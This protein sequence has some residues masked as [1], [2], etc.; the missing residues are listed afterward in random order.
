MPTIKGCPF[1][2][3]S[4]NDWDVLLW[5]ER[6]DSPCQPFSPAAISLPDAVKL[7]HRQGLSSLFRP[8]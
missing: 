4:M 1:E 7:Y 2:I 3:S 6:T 8:D 5:Y